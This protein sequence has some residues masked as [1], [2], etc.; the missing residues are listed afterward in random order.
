MRAVVFD[1]D[2]VICRSMALHARAYRETMQPLGI[3]VTDDQVYQLEGGRSESLIRQFLEDAGRPADSALV[4]RLGKEK[5]EAFRRLGPPTLY[6]GAEGM[7]RR[8]RAKAQMIGIVTGTRREN[9]ERLI[10]SLLPL[11]DQVL[12]QEAYTKDKPDPEPY[13][14]TAQAL[15]IPAPECIALENAPFGVR[16]ARAAGYGHV[17]AITTTVGRQQL[18]DCGADVIV[19][20]HAQAADAVLDA[21]ADH[22]KP[23]RGL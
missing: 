15:G 11:F 13:A 20:D 23:Q 18:R 1:F 19:D 5:Q 6:E 7:V 14:K 4:S 12:A 17:V 3:H 16:S 22:P 9:L 2:G 21:L 8:V 10:P